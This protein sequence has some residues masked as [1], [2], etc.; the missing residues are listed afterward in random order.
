MVSASGVGVYAVVA[1]CIIS[2]IGHFDRQAFVSLPL[3]GRSNAATTLRAPAVPDVIGLHRLEKSGTSA[4][5]FVP[6]VVLTALALRVQRRRTACR[7]LGSCD[8]MYFRRGL[9]IYP[10][11]A[12]K[13]LRN[14]AYNIYMK[15]RFKRA[16]RFV[17]R[18]AR[19]LYAGDRNPENMGAV[20]EEMK[21]GLDHFFKMC[22]EACVQGVIKTKEAAEWKENICVQLMKACIKRKFIERPKDPFLPAFKVLGYEVPACH[23][24]REPRPWQLPGWKS[25]WVLKREYDAYQR[26]TRK[27]EERE[28]EKA[29]A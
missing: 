11:R 3:S 21:E 16:G 20:M 1:A 12:K 10:P 23:L 25:P 15:N 26:R 24:V 29:E 27:R 17:K 7:S 18:Y 19:E 28:K 5:G 2:C 8:T 4:F 13:N 9:L 6:L 14:R 22:D